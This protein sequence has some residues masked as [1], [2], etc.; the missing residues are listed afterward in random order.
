[1]IIIGL[2]VFNLRRHH[3]LKPLHAKLRPMESLVSTENA[4]SPVV[5][6]GARRVTPC[7]GASM[8]RLQ[9]EKEGRII[10][11]RHTKASQQE[12]A[13]PL[14]EAQVKGSETSRAAATAFAAN[15]S[16]VVRQIYAAD[17]AP[18]RTANDDT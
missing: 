18:R 6:A 7:G 9:N 10:A 16:P 14:G 1:V 17:D 3:G 4:L 11:E 12:L 8:R 2:G 5:P 13:E 15:V